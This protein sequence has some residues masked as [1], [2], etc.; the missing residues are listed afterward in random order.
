MTPRDLGGS[1]EMFTSGPWKS[2]QTISALSGPFQ[3][4]GCSHLPWLLQRHLTSLLCVPSTGIFVLRSVV[5]EVL[6]PLLVF[7]PHHAVWMCQLSGQ[8]ELGV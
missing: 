4:H 5:N 1:C 7:L 6:S 8:Q 3:M 2:A